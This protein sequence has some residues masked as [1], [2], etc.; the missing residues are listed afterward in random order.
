MFSATFNNILD[1]WLGGLWCLVPLYHK[2]PNQPSKILLK[3][4]L[5]TINHPT[6]DGWLGGLWCLVPLST[7][8]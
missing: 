7:I 5:N 6:K 8:S 2:P 3:V 4:A 1:D